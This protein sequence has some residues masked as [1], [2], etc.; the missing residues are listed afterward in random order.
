ML[1]LLASKSKPVINFSI[2]PLIELVKRN[3]E[4]IEVRPVLNL[5]DYDDITLSDYEN[6]IYADFCKEFADSNK[7]FSIPKHWKQFS[8]TYLTEI[9]P[10]DSQEIEHKSVEEIIRIHQIWNSLSALVPNIQDGEGK[11]E[12]FEIKRMM[13]D[14]FKSQYFCS[15]FI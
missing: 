14:L 2:S 7:K 11:Q 12:Y 1:I 8:S 3:I 6:I 10:Y 9:L 13:M 4:N 15:I 5:A